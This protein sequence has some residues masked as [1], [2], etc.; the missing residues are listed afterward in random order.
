MIVVA[1]RSSERSTMVMQ[2]LWRPA[3]WVSWAMSRGGRRSVSSSLVAE[4]LTGG[5][6]WRLVCSPKVPDPVAWAAAADEHWPSEIDPEVKMLDRVHGIP[7]PADVQRWILDQVE[8]GQ[9]PALIAD[10]MGIHPDT[11]TRTVNRQRSTA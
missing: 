3:E 5:E 8:L 11:V 6:R 10:R 7:I 4:L 1:R 9:S 2:T